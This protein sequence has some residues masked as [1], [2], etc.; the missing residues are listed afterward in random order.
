M[1]LFGEFG[2]GGDSIYNTLPVNMLSL[3]AKELN[4]DVMLDWSTASELNNKGFDVENSINGLNFNYLKFVK[5]AGNSSVL[6]N[7][8]TLDEHAF[9]LNHSDKLYYRLKQV[10]A[11]GKYNYSGMVLVSHKENILNTIISY[12]NP[13]K[14]NMTLEI[15][16]GSKGKGEINITDVR[17]IEILSMQIIVEK[18]NN[19]I[20]L[21]NFEN[22]SNG[23]YF[24][25]VL[26]NGD[27]KTMKVTKIQ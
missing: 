3:S 10:D 6:T 8:S 7:Y 11:D 21:V 24:V 1:T 17:G 26:V 15:N 19:K 20:D 12:P 18:G 2:I 16:S 25:R 4:G 23:I 13:F 14:Q 9:D 27:Y 22:L 5:G